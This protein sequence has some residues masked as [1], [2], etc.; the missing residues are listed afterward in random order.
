MGANISLFYYAGFC[1]MMMRRY[2]LQ[3]LWQKCWQGCHVSVF[4]MQSGRLSDFGC[5][6]GAV[7][8]QSRQKCRM[9]VVKVCLGRTL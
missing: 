7:L 8:Q 9:A 1:Y 4:G 2:V 3:Q 6:D 5:C